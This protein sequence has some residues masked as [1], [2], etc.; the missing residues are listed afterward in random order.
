MAKKAVAPARAPKKPAGRKDT[1][2]Q[3][4]GGR[5]N[6]EAGGETHQIAEGDVETLT[7]QQGIPVADDQ[8]TL[9]QGARGPALI[10]STRWNSRNRFRR[11]AKAACI[12]CS[13]VVASSKSI[14]RR[15][16]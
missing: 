6:L 8:N 5:E 15:T 10:A 13:R 9:R 7:T 12:S 1:S 2:E 16:G 14:L 11:A 4:K 3:A